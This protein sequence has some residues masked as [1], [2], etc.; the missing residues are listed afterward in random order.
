MT[1]ITLGL[2][3]CIESGAH[4]V[5]GDPASH[6]RARQQ[7]NPPAA[8][9]SIIRAIGRDGIS[10]PRALDRF[11]RR[12]HCPARLTFACTQT[13][14]PVLDLAKINTVFQRKS[15]ALAQFG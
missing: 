8:R 3:C 14:Q 7:T 12:T 10:V 6:R 1:S 2:N 5:S 4:S 9:F 11:L 15:G 13:A